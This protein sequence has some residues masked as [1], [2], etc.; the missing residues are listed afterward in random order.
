MSPLTGL[1]SFLISS[2]A[3]STA[4][5]IPRFNAI[6][7]APAATVLTPSRKIDCARTVAVV[8]PSPAMSEVFEATSRTICAPVFSSLSSSSISL[9]TVTP[10]LVIVGDPNFFSMT[11]LRPLGPRVTFTASASLFTP[12]SSARRDSSPYAMCLAICILLL[13]DCLSSFSFS[14]AFS[15]PFD[16]TQDVVLA[17]DQIVLII[18][19]HLSSGILAEKHTVSLFDVQGDSLSAIELLACAYG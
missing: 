7:L 10:S 12:V 17:H 16:H 5:S 19:L 6:G 18:E 2:T 4:L 1:E 11:T 3:F 8:V 9:A 15:G 13:K 14:L